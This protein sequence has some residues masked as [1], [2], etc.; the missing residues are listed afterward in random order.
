MLKNKFWTKFIVYIIYNTKNIYIN[1]FMIFCLSTCT[2]STT[3]YVYMYVPV[4][5]NIASGRFRNNVK[6][7]KLG[8]SQI[9]KPTALLVL[10]VNC[11]TCHGCEQSAR[12]AQQ[13]L[14]KHLALQTPHSDA[15]RHRQR[16]GRHLAPA[17]ASTTLTWFLLLSAYSASLRT[18]QI[19]TTSS[20]IAT[21]FRQNR[22]VR[23]M[24]GWRRN[25]H[26]VWYKPAKL[27]TE[28]LKI[29]RLDNYSLVDS[30]RTGKP[31]SVCLNWL[32]ALGNKIFKTKATALTSH[33]VGQARFRP[34]HCSVT[35]CCFAEWRHAA[36]VN[37]QSVI[38]VSRQ[39]ASWWIFRLS[40]LD[41]LATR[42]QIGQT[43]VKNRERNCWL[44][45]NI[46]Q[47]WV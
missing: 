42:L 17:A 30:D 35:C 13:S 7:N 47:D 36:P 28:E 6:H 31:V 34:S 10:R 16:S 24:S 38:G 23:K 8:L 29:F 14:R 45:K 41:V 27:S 20:P 12:N 19:P 22:F 32:K 46:R 2:C 9:F 21:Q 25:K 3:K 1:S 11:G 37:K 15:V 43:F 26:R 33:C 44:C 40:C 39:S 4:Y 18:Q 5:S